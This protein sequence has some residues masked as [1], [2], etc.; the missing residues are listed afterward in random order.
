MF[1]GWA[2]KAKDN[3]NMDFGDSIIRWNCFY[4]P[5]KIVFTFSW[6]AAHLLPTLFWQA[7]QPYLH[8]RATNCNMDSAIISLLSMLA[9]SLQC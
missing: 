3:F 4:N 5:I 2:H 7:K 9:M 6:K 1:I 8:T